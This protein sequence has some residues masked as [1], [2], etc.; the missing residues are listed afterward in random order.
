MYSNL[1]VLLTK[2][3]LKSYIYSLDVVICKCCCYYYALNIRSHEL[4]KEGGNR[5]KVQT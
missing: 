5:K 4:K 3:I 1:N 2:Y